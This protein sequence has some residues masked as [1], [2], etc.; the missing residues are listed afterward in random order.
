MQRPADVSDAD[1]RLRGPLGMYDTGNFD[2]ETGGGIVQRVTVPYQDDGFHEP[3]YPFG[4]SNND[5]DSNML[6][7]MN[8]IQDNDEAAREQESLTSGTAYR[9]SIRGHDM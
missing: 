5:S 6:N 2:R 8:G 7:P 4:T 1:P 3:Y 9:K